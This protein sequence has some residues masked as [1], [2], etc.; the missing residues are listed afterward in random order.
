MSLNKQTNYLLLI[1]IISTS[2]IF[3]QHRIKPNEVGTLGNSQDNT[4]IALTSIGL[5]PTKYAI[6]LYSDSVIDK[7]GNNQKMASHLVNR[8]SGA[9]TWQ[10]YMPEAGEYELAINYATKADGC[11]VK[12]VAD[13]D[14]ISAGLAVTAGYYPSTRT[15]WFAFNCERKQIPGKLHLNKGMNTVTVALTG[16]KGSEINIYS[17]E[18]IP[19]AKK[20]VITND[21]KKSANVKPNRNW[22]TKSPYGL[23][24]HWTSQSAPQHGPLKPYNEAVNSF[25]V[26][27]FVKMVQKTGA[28]YIIFTT[29]HAEP[30][31][32]AP[33]KQWEAE[34]PGHTTT[35]DLVAEISDSLQKHNIKLMLYL[36]THIYAK[37]DK[38]NDEEF[39]RL[40]FS[41]LNEIGERY[42][43]KVAGYWLDGWYQSYSKHPTF[44]F[45]KLYKI[46]KK[47]N[48][49][50]LLT[51]N[52]WVYPVATTWQDYWAGEVYNIGNPAA[53]QILENGPGKGLQAQSLI[54]METDDWLHQPLNTDIKAPS[55]KALDLANFINKQKGKG[56]VTVNIQIYQDGRISDEALKIMETV[57]QQLKQ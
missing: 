56:P 45:E 6:V 29:N 48:P 24:F 28:S 14:S 32:P 19:A 37:Y 11:T 30:Y 34:Y 50:R 12:V 5:M 9:L 15:D 53:K 17:I 46:C 20:A 33:L 2:S 39:N 40:N 13:Q 31:F 44:D 55:L 38:V 42:K 22:F 41:L 3:A 23:M 4:P 35:R 43:K 8:G 1:L 10:K 16:A 52:S 26:S 21:L 47:G 18:L 51:L 25:N 36:A 7:K 27:A 49:N 57:S 54:V